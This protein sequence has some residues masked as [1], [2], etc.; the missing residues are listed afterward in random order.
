MIR[1]L[2][3]LSEAERKEKF[4]KHRFLVQTKV[5]EDGEYEKIMST[6]PNDRGD[7]VS[8]DIHLIFL[9]CEDIKSFHV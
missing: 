2:L 9:I 4:E 8:S 3:D 7:E 1:R 5:I 6:S